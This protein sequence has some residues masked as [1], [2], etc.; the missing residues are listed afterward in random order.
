M[1]KKGRPTTERSA[2]MLKTLTDAYEKLKNGYPSFD[3]ITVKANQSDEIRFS[4]EGKI[5]DKTLLQSKNKDIKVLRERIQ[6][7]KK[8]IAELKAIAPT[9]LSIKIEQLHSS[10]QANNILANK[11]ENRDKRLRNK[12][13]ALDEKDIRI[14]ELSKEIARLRAELRQIKV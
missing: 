5:G 2:L 8:D 3:D 11:V 4:K 10:L 13:K 12:D 14:T 1:G 6:S 7:D 9:E